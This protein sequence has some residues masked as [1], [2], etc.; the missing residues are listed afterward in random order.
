MKPSDLLLELL[1]N[2]F[3][4]A[5]VA[6]T[7]VER[8]FKDKGIPYTHVYPSSG[9]SAPTLSSLSHVHSALSNTIPS[10]C[11]QSSHILKNSLQN[12]NAFEAAMPN[13]RVIPLAWWSSFTS[14]VSTGEK[15][16]QVVMCVKLKYVQRPVGRRA[17][18]MGKGIIRPSK[19][20]IYDANEAVVCFLADEA[21]GCVD[22]F[23]KEWASVSQI[24][25]IAREGDKKI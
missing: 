3:Y 6:H 10:L 9:L 1:F 25:V 19:R 15:P 18:N 20:I 8:Q 22:L 5:R 16:P 4:S 2:Y 14:A 7:K 24:V 13:I 21:E 17:A 12:S 11:V 23:Q